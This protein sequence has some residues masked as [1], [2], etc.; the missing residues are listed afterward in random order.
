VLG[1]QIHVGTPMTIQF[2][3]LRLKKG[4]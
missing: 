1:L 3:D 4:L 2:K